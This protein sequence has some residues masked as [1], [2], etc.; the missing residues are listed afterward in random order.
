MKRKKGIRE[1]HRVK[2]SKSTS[3]R[4]F[5]KEIEFFRKLNEEHPPEYVKSKATSPRYY[6]C[7]QKLR[8]VEIPGAFRRLTIPS[9]LWSNKNTIPLQKGKQTRNIT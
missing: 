7:A 1:T 3:S 4:L 5:L 8:P 2:L 9:G 6:Q